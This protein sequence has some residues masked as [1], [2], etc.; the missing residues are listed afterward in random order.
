MAT[1]SDILDADLL[2][3]LAGDRYFQRGVDY[4]ERGLVHSMAQYDERIVAEV[5]GT[6]IYQIQ[7]WLEGT[8]LLSRCSCPLGVDGLFCK[9]CV[10]V[11]LAWISEPPPYRREQ[12][13]PKKAGTTME[14]VRDYLTRQER[15]TLVQMILDQAMDD[16][17]WRDQ[18]LL[19]AAFSQPGGADINTFRRT[20]RNA[21][22]TGDFVDYY[23]AAGYAEEVQTAIDGLEELLDEG[24]ALTA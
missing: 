7:L 12:E 8:D 19:K 1:L 22:A 20:L 4:F 18:L 13:T 9:H 6:E 14:D 2:M 17:R 5:Y 11:G 24:Y 21:I 23:A 10:A 16:A 3:D 15:D